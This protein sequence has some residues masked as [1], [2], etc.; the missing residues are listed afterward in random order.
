VLQGPTDKKRTEFSRSITEVVSQRIIRQSFAMWLVSE[1]M[2]QA[3]LC[4]ATPRLK[5][6]SKSHE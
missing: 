3:P 6:P 2:L 5:K 4:R 1:R